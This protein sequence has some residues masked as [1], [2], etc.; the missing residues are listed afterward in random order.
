MSGRPQNPKLRHELLALRAED[1]RVRTMLLEAGELGG[2]Y[3]PEMEHVHRRNAA[4]FRELLAEHG[5]WPGIDQVGDDGAEA[6]WLIVQ[7]AI[8]EPEF[9]RSSL[10][11]LHV[12]VAKRQAPAW[13]AAY[14]EDRIAMYEGRPQRYGSQWMDD[15]VDGCARPWQL[16]DPE[17][18]DELRARVGLAPLAP[19]PPPG[20]PLPADEQAERAEDA[21]WWLE[22]LASRGWKSDE[23]P[24]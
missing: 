12:A 3:V 9:M 15:P 17:H 22:W 7:H 6:A 4:R 10:A 11:I 1:K 16:A 5:G 20:S 13:H 8:G 24:N 23:K 18:I 19:I 21:A 14:L 2:P